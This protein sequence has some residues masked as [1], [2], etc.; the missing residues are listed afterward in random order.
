MYFG[1]FDML[2]EILPLRKDRISSI[3]K[4]SLLADMAA[5]MARNLST[6]DKVLSFPTALPRKA[7]MAGPF[8]P[9]AKTNAT[10]IYG[11]FFTN[12][13]GGVA[14]NVVIV[15]LLTKPPHVSFNLAAFSCPRVSTPLLR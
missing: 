3:S 13:S 4:R 12:I 14:I 7:L 5:S 8:G 2:Q 1:N 11:R 10:T 15:A 6:S 9:T